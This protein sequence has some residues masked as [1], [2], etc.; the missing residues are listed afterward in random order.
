M[1]ARITDDEAKGFF[2]SLNEHAACELMCRT[3]MPDEHEFHHKDCPIADGLRDCWTTPRWLT[4]LLPK[5]TL[6]PCSNL[7]ST[8]RAKR[9][10]V[11]SGDPYWNNFH[12]I[13]GTTQ[14]EQGDGLAVSWK[15]R[16]VFVNPPYSKIMPWARKAADARAFI[17]LVN[18]DPSTKWMKELRES[19]GHFRFEFDKRIKFVPPPRIRQS[20]NSKPQALICNEAGMLMIDEDLKQHGQWWQRWDWYQRK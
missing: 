9:H 8:V 14:W 12:D 11:S 15:N 4:D 7:R 2:K 19:G 5:V 18:L 13:D 20:S 16:S 1:S 3:G 6:D 10:I 17:F